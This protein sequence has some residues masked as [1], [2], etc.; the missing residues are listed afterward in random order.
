MERRTG[1]RLGARTGALLGVAAVLCA[2]L[3]GIGRLLVA[4]APGLDVD[5]VRW[6]A[7]H[8]TDQ[9]DRI[10]A[11]VTG[12]VSTEMVIGLGLLAAVVGAVLRRTWWPAALM[13][14]AL[15][16]EL[17]IFL[18]TA[19]VVGRARPPVPPVGGVLPPTSSFP[20]GHTAATVCLYGGIAAIVLLTT[21]RWWR[22]L[23]VAAVVLLVIA[24]AV[25]RVY[26]GAHHPT[27]VLAGALLGT[28]WLLSTIRAIRPLPPG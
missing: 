26:R 15:V 24:V 28:V 18:L 25:S 27:D 9:L 7:A 12:L 17:A 8:R 4:A 13:V 6:M 5:V 1:R 21:S 2:G 14:I 20:S 19:M 16:G 3:I 22:H 10:S 11:T 23:V